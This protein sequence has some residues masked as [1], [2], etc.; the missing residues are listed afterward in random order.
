MPAVKMIRSGKRPGFTCD[1]CRVREL[2]PD[3]GAAKAARMKHVA[4][5]PHRSSLRA[6]RR[7]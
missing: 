4:S 5:A 1:V 2:Y 7:E 3:A 6:A